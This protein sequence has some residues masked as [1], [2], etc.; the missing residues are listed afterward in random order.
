MPKPNLSGY[1]P[2]LREAIVRRRNE[3][4]AKRGRPAE[5]YNPATG[6]VVERDQYIQ[7][8]VDA[9]VAEAVA[10]AVTPARPA[11]HAPRTPITEAVAAATP[12]EP[13]APAVTAGQ[14]AAMPDEQRQAV[15]GDALG[16]VFAEQDRRRASRP[17]PFWQ[18]LT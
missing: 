1:S 6:E 11:G 7:A 5:I 13:E 4:L 15:L 16:S 2:E 17:A 3:K 12:A 10:A 8:V 9:R 14:L 18:G